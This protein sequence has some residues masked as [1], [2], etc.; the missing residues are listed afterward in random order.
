[1]VW[2][3]DNYVSAEPCCRPEDG[4]RRLRRKFNNFVTTT[5]CHNAQ[6]NG[7]EGIFFGCLTS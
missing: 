3:I 4:S 7:F 5:G 1:V 6:R 2:E